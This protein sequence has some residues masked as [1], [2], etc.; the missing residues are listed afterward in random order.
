[1]F[2]ETNLNVTGE[3]DLVSIW[4]AEGADFAMS[5]QSG[6][7]FARVGRLLP[8]FNQFLPVNDNNKSKQGNK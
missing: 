6:S 2:I 5:N 7:T 3:V 8:S 4:E 1:M